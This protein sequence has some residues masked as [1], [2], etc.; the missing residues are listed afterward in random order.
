MITKRQYT[1]FLDN[2]FN[3]RTRCYFCMGGTKSK[4]IVYH[5]RAHNLGL[6]GNDAS[7]PTLYFH[8]DCFRL[9]AGE[10]FMFDFFKGNCR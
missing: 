8:V 7:T 3:G 6:T 5:I 2:H 9:V 10:D 1:D 4:E